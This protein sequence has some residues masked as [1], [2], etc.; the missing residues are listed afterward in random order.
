MGVVLQSNRNSN[1]LKYQ[2]GTKRGSS[3][4]IVV[5][6]C[7][8]NSDVLDVGCASGYLG[9][10]LK[11]KGCQIWGVDN[12]R[13]ALASIPNGIYEE[14]RELDLNSVVEDVPL[15]PCLFDVIILADVLE[16]LV[17][18]SATLKVLIKSI[19]P[20]GQFIISLPNVAHISIRASLLRG[21]FDYVDRGI[22]DRTHLHLYTYDSAALLLQKCGLNVERTLAG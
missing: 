12:D 3:T 18:P 20:N 4:N 1:P 14:V 17:N 7:P 21:H 6:A 9:D 2:K 22:L 15:F 10:E 13:I 5:G 19:K 11:R 8:V 16:H